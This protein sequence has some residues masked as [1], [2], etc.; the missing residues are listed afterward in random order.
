MDKFWSLL[1]TNHLASEIDNSERTDLLFHVNSKL[2]RRILSPNM[3]ESRTILGHKDMVNVI[4]T[5]EKRYPGS[6]IVLLPEVERI[7]LTVGDALRQRRSKLGEKPGNVSLGQLSQ[8]LW[9]GNG[10]IG[11][12]KF[13]RTAPSGGALYPCEMYVFSRQSDLVPGIYHYCPRD[14]SL[15]CISSD[16]RWEELFVPGTEPITASIVIAITASF[17]RAFFKYGER[18]YRFIL[19][20]AGA[21]AQNMALS[22]CDL[23]LGTLPH[24]GYCDAEVEKQLDIDGLDESVVHVVAVGTLGDLE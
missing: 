9:A 6:E 12:E 17:Q 7:N 23:N 1:F 19:L 11:E 22:A 4:Q 3:V 16:L 5:S 15:E 8:L 10:V 13:Y 20:E 14:H 2:S 21:I 18:S 24:G